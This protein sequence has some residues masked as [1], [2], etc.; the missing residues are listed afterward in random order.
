[1]DATC[2]SETSIAFKQTIRRYI[3]E[4]K[5]LHPV[6]YWKQTRLKSIYFSTSCACCKPI[7]FSPHIAL[8]L[9]AL[10]MRSKAK[11][12]IYSLLSFCKYGAI[13]LQSLPHFFL[14][15]CLLALQ[16]HALKRSSPV[17]VT[18][19]STSSISWRVVK[20]VS[21]WSIAEC[22]VQKRASGL[23]EVQI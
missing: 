4:G 12:A 2:F 8:V 16:S 7:F 5:T 1:M 11:M 6:I 23:N 13:V 21:C 20:F 17:F 9:E 14:L 22:G 3:R 19:S 18:E 15:I 10:C